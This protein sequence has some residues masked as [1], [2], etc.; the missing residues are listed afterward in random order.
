MSM[1]S[2]IRLAAFAA[3]TSLAA[4]TA[5]AQI[6]IPTVTIG[7]PGNAADPFTGN[8]YGSVEYTYNIGTTEVTNAQYA[9]FLNAKAASDPHGLYSQYMGTA[10]PGYGVLFGGI[11][12]SGSDGSYTYS[13]VTGRANNPVN[14]VSFWDAT[15]FAN[16]L[17]NGQG[18]GDTETGAYTLGGV[19]NPVNSSITRNPCWKWAVTSEDEWYK[20]AYHQ[21]ASAGGDSDNYWVWPTQSNAAPTT[22]QANILRSNAVPVGSYAP[23][24]YGTFDMGGNVMEWN[25][26]IVFDYARRSRG[27]DFSNDVALL[28]ARTA[29]EWEPLY[30]NPTVGFR[31]SA[32]GLPTVP[33]VV[34]T[35]PFG[36]AAVFVAPLGAGSFTYE[37]Q[38]EDLGAPGTWLN[39]P[40]GPLVISGITWGTISDATTDTLRAQP[41]PLTYLVAGTLRFR[42]I[43][44]NACGS[45]A[46]NPATLTVCAADFDCSDFLD[47][48]DFILYVSQFTLGCDGPGS[49][50]PACTQSADFDGTGFVDSDDF[51]AYV[52]AFEAGC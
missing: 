22:A 7:N 21:P 38:V 49:P 24:Y 29:V 6:T 18:N 5:S 40:D 34:R 31:V 11:T 35:C 16:W 9:A 44:T 33:N 10:L 8:L 15:R 13:T 20:A 42:C 46:S 47:S 43:V 51:V 12:R 32:P 3:V 27:G 45:G 25:E 28:W 23:N 52:H 37:W 50:D 39:L 19:T 2:L 41:N 48:D 26:L 36:T 30:E 4:S 14:F 1:K 17:H